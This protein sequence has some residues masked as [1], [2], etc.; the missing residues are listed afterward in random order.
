MYHRANGIRKTEND[1][2]KQGDI[3]LAY[4]QKLRPNMQ[5]MTARDHK[6]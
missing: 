4:P 3:T 6:N 5:C 1:N 2:H